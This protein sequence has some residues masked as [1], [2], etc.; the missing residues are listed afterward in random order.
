M[1]GASFFQYTHHL[2]SCQEKSH[3]AL[4]FELI[5]R[6]PILFREVLRP[7]GKGIW[8]ATMRRLFWQGIGRG[9]APVISG[10]NF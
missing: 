4:H 6:K 5:I 9:D 2:M 7:E 1:P 10:E 8:S 3:F